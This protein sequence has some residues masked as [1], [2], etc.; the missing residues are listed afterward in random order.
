MITLGCKEKFFIHPKVLEETNSAQ[1]ESCHKKE[2]VEWKSSAHGISGTN[3]RFKEAYKLET[4]AS[5]IHCHSPLT[6]KNSNYAKKK[7]IE[8]GVGCITCHKKQFDFPFYISFYKNKY[9]CGYCHDFPFPQG[10][11]LDLKVNPHPLGIGMQTTEK[12]FKETVWHKKK[13]YTC[14]NCHFPN[15]KHSLG[16]PIDR[17]KFIKNFHFSF[18]YFKP[19]NTLVTKLEIPKIGHHFPT[20]DLFRS[21]WIEVFDDS[22]RQIGITK[23]QKNMNMLTRKTISNNRLV[24]NSEGK[25][26]KEIWITLKGLPKKCKISYHLQGEI[27]NLLGHVPTEEL[28]IEL[29]NGKC[30]WN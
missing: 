1:C 24:P 8:E 28:I 6:L 26:E 19:I 16:G 14:I 12:E 4:K 10:N 2:F 18:E 17:E 15:G 29:Y 21:F 13:D 9:D 7:D 30:G 22:D 3:I 11:D 20:G 27:E 5:C 23:I 25:I